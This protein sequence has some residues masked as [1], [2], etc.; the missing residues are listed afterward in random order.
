MADFF[1]SIHTENR[2]NI[3]IPR[4]PLLVCKTS[5]RASRQRVIGS[6]P[7]LIT[8]P[9]PPVYHTLN[10]LPRPARLLRSIP[11]ASSPS[12]LVRRSKPA[13]QRT[14]FHSSA[15]QQGPTTPTGIREKGIS[16]DAK[17]RVQQHVRKLQSSATS[18]AAPAVRPAPAQH[19]QLPQNPLPSSA[20]G[21]DNPLDG[22]KVKDGMDYS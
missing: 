15:S 21:T 19:F 5:H 9:L 3:P 16:I 14:A 6:S 13:A 10:M 22:S 17:A 8:S 2:Y 4:S 18:G 20:P 1:D 11:S 7:P 12:L